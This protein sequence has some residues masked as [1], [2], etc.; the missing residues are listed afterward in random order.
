MMIRI[1]KERL[2]GILSTRSGAGKEKPSVSGLLYQAPPLPFGK[3]APQTPAEF[4]TGIPVLQGLTKKEAT[5]LASLMHERSYGAGE[6]IFDQGSPSAALYLIRSGCVE[7]FRG[8]GATDEVVA[9]LGPNEHFSEVALLTDEARR[10]VSAR[11]R[12]PSEL[13]ALSRQ[14][15]DSLMTRSPVAGVK[16]L[17]ALARIVALRFGILLEALEGGAEE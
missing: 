14:D 1:H 16:V 5:V 13:L 4:L 11:S 7:L 15:F 9:T 12:G 8:A 6:T 3:T 17:R 2:L 10:Q